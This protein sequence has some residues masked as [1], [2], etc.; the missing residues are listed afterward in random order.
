MSVPAPLPSTMTTRVI[1]CIKSVYAAVQQNCLIREIVPTVNS[2]MLMARDPEP[3]RALHTGKGVEIFLNFARL[4]L[5]S[6]AAVIRVLALRMVREWVDGRRAILQLIRSR[7]DFLVGQCL[8]Q[9]AGAEAAGVHE[10]VE[11]VKLVNRIVCLDSEHFESRALL[12]S[13]IAVARDP[14][15]SCW[16]LCIEL[17]RRVVVNDLSLAANS[18][19]LDVLFDAALEPSCRSIA[20]TVVLTLLYLLNEP[21]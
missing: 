15:H 11:A 13:L 20:K 9:P 21:K 14:D 8:E 1:D 7:L 5:Q 6:N 16:L 10:R 18:S 12:Q 2:I 3:K 19:A 4:L 17:V